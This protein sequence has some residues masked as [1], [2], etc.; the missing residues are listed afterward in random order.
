MTFEFKMNRDLTQKAKAFLCLILVAFLVN[1]VVPQVGFA[2]ELDNSVNRKLAFV[3]LENEDLISL[4]H[5]EFRKNPP[6]PKVLQ[7]RTVISTAY[8]SS[9]AETDSTP[10]ITADGYDVCAAGVENVVAANFLRFGTKVRIPD[11][12]GDRIFVVH[13]RMNERFSSRVDVW[14]LNRNDALSY[15]KRLVKIEVVE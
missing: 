7:T 14:M 15:G 4:R 6:Q 10:C 11:Q 1:M 2:E 12:F 3:S 13:D 9:V 5:D 8:T